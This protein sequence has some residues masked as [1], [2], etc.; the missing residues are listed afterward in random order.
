[1][2]KDIQE[3]KYLGIKQMLLCKNYNKNL[4]KL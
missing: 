4:N 3:L 2:S 1:M